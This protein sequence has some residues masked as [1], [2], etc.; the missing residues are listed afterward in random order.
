MIARILL[1][2]LAMG[3]I[4]AAFVAPS[5]AHQPRDAGSD[6]AR[7]PVVRVGEVTAVDAGHARRFSGQLRGA[8]RGQLA[9]T[10]G[11]RLSARP[12][13]IG[14]RVAA[15][16]VLARLDPLPLQN[17]VAA[18]RARLRRIEAELAQSRRTHVR[19][20]RLALARAL[21]DMELEQTGSTVESLEA[22][23]DEAQ[24]ELSEARRQLR[25]GTLRAP[26]DGVVGDVLVEPGE[27]VSLGAPVVVYSDADGLELE[28]EVPERILSAI[29]V[30]RTVAVD[31]P[32][33]GRTVEA[34]VVGVGHVAADRG[35][36]FPVVVRLPA[37]EG[38]R[39]GVTAELVL[40]VER[41]AGHAVPIEAVVNPGG[42]QPSVF[43]VVDDVVHERTVDVARVVGSKA[44]VTG[45]SPG[46]R[47]V[48]G[49][50]AGLISG[51]TVEV[52]R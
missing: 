8:H 45:V 31:L 28:V 37:A 21:P 4:A 6:R 17:R 2:L 15:G 14:D 26:F 30:G 27:M 51:E 43:V 49:G 23:R 39:P 25:E 11:G 9:F 3:G 33:L 12:V 10:I 32:L 42:A 22:S 19:T 48:I 41:A 24:A 29:E 18:A 38:L 36:L 46:D 47:V 13:E 40:E 52:A 7:P 34:E 35:R 1:G 44:I 16:D 20:E 50:H 5:F